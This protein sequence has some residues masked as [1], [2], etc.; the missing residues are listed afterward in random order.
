MPARRAMIGSGIPYS[1]QNA[2]T[3]KQVRDSHKRCA[4]SASSSSLF[5]TK[6]ISD[7]RIVAP[8]LG[9]CAGAPNDRSLMV[10]PT[11]EENYATTLSAISPTCTSSKCRYNKHLDSAWNVRLTRAGGSGQCK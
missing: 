9:R 1:S 6:Q 3:D 8:D 4:P 10:G 7:D 2:L 5:A 11:E